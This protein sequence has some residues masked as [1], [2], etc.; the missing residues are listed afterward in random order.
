MEGRV[1]N[2][3]THARTHTHTHTHTHTRTH[4]HTHAVHVS[5]YLLFILNRIGLWDA[6][7]AQ[8]THT[9]K[10]TNCTAHHATIVLTSS[11]LQVICT[12]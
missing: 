1:S 5:L 2:V 8:L 7:H 9:Y 6:E 3:I 4:T 12:G 11:N 10:G